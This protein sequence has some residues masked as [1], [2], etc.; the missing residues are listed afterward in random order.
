[1]IKRLPI[2][3]RLWLRRLLL[4]CL[5]ALGLARPFPNRGMLELTAIRE[6]QVDVVNLTS[7]APD[8]TPANMIAGDSF[9]LYVPTCCTQL[10]ILL[11]AD[12]PD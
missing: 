11:M 6:M 12:A 2:N 9:S 3:W 4:R 10:T 1:M 7:D 5:D 8:P